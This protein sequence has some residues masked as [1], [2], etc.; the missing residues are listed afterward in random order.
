MDPG[1][2]LTSAK[3]HVAIIDEYTNKMV[4]FD[5]VFL[6]FE[7]MNNKDCLNLLTYRLN[8]LS[9]DPLYQIFYL[10]CKELRFGNVHSH[11]SGRESC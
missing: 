4:L 6:F 11:P 5:V 1:K 8:T 2:K 7:I 10:F 3:P 9:G